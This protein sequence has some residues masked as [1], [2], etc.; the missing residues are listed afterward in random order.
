[1]TKGG[2]WRTWSHTD[3]SSQGQNLAG[4]SPRPRH[5]SQFPHKGQWEGSPTHVRAGKAEGFP[6]ELKWTE[7]W[8]WGQNPTFSLSPFLTTRKTSPSRIFTSV[9]TNHPSVLL[10]PTELQGTGGFR[11]IYT[12][13]PVFVGLERW[14]LTFSFALRG[15]CLPERPAVSRGSLSQPAF[16]PSLAEMAWPLLG[17]P[18]PGLGGLLNSRAEKDWR[19]LS[20]S[21][22]SHPGD[23]HRMVPQPHFPSRDM[24]L[25]VHWSNTLVSPW[26]DVLC[27]CTRTCTCP[28]MHITVHT[29][30]CMWAH[31]WLR[32]YILAGPSEINPP[33]FIC[34]PWAMSL[35]LS[36][37]GV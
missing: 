6:A 24:C 7:W 3:H 11:N 1:M 27:M 25:W 18:P 14:T 16:S 22:M 29:H 12:D 34:I 31:R 35:Y 23:C 5:P 8:F 32:S 13:R 28:C 36:L 2:W 37:S 4:P 21:Q 17:N 9:R 26:L 20:R 15:P 19:D 30:T 33:C 10:F